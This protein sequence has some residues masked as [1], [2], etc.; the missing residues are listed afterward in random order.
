MRSRCLRISTAILFITNKPS[1]F[2][3]SS[4]RSSVSRLYRQPTRQHPFGIYR[5]STFGA[6]VFYKRYWEYV[7]ESTY[8]LNLLAVHNYVKSCRSV[9]WV[10]WAARGLAKVRCFPFSKMT[11]GASGNWLIFCL[12]WSSRLEFACARVRS[13]RLRQ[14]N[15]RLLRANLPVS[16]ASS[17]VQ[18]CTEYNFIWQ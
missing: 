13:R 14:R 9:G 15:L 5:Q 17:S 12:S 16:R 6:P 10:G 7:F 4:A 1:L 18:I 8:P 3:R 11:N 2:R